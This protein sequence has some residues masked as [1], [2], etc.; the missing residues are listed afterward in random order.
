M[1][2][3]ERA[4]A[5]EIDTQRHTLPIAVAVISE[6]LMANREL[7]ESENMSSS[8]DTTDSS[9]GQSSIVDCPS[10]LSVVD[11]L[12][13]QPPDLLQH[14]EMPSLHPDDNDAVSRDL[15]SVAML[16]CSDDICQPQAS[17]PTVLEKHE[18]SGKNTKSSLVIV[19][20]ETTERNEDSTE[21]DMSS[22]VSVI[23]HHQDKDSSVSCQAE[24][25]C[26]S[27]DVAESVSHSFSASD[28]VP[29]SKADLYMCCS[30]DDMSVKESCSVSP[31]HQ[32]SESAHSSRTQSQNGTD[33]DRISNNM[34][35]VKRVVTPKQRT[36]AN[37]I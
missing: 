24:L 18:S 10:S 12:S 29:E 6:L 35:A 11:K 20:S 26:A 8:F 3:V 2:S 33:S 22:T 7:I 1:K 21:T 31:D 32:Q 14:T 36:T 9:V 5:Q 34:P 16:Q 23:S 4:V 17:D 19:N 30:D 37:G 28:M 13:S 27:A 15:S 25:D